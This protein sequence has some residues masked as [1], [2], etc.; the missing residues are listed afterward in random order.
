MMNDGF[1]KKSFDEPTRTKLRLYGAYVKAWLPVFM[2]GS[3]RAK[4][5]VVYDLFCGA[6][7][8]SSG[9]FGSPLILLHELKKSLL[10]LGKTTPPIELYFNDKEKNKISH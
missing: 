9:A 8:D 4:K 3:S 6:G 7:S 1:H 10:R 2:S 5:I